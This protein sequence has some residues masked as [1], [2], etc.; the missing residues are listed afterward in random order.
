M[1]SVRSRSSRKAGYGHL[2]LAPGGLTVLPSPL[3]TL[4]VG[5]SPTAPPVALQLVA[6]APPKALHEA[7]D[8]ADT[9]QTLDRVPSPAVPDAPWVEQFWPFA[10]P[11]E[12]HC[13]VAPPLAE[14]L[15]FPP[16]PPLLAEQVPA[17][18]PPIL[19]VLHVW[20]TSPLAE[21]VA[22]AA[23]VPFVEQLPPFVVLH[24]FDPLPDAFELV[25]HCDAPPPP[26]A[27]FAEQYSVA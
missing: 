17:L 13:T 11:L 10:A 8:P 16:P 25:L 14:Q 18:P 20:F 6:A 19:P 1:Q 23:C 5:G 21:H 7:E 15:P 27:G 2:L 3:I 22:P 26:A 9:E 4:Q 24:V 12:L